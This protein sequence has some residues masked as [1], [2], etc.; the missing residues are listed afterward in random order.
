MAYSINLTFTPEKFFLVDWSWFYSKFST[1]FPLAEKN[2][3][4]YLI[5]VYWGAVF[6]ILFKTSSKVSEGSLEMRDYCRTS[7][8][9]S[10]SYYGFLQ[11][12]FRTSAVLKNYSYY[13]LVELQEEMIRSKTISGTSMSPNLSY[14]LIVS[15]KSIKSYF[16]RSLDSDLRYDKNSFQDIYSLAFLS[17]SHPNKSYI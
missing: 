4:S 3:S 7:E 10:L 15:T 13:L 14:F 2:S 9:F 6:L 8:Y 17:S 5:V 11:I 16:E 12:A 1:G